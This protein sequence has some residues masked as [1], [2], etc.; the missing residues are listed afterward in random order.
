MNIFCIFDS[1]DLVS[2]MVL[3][4][5]VT[6]FGGT[7]IP[8]WFYPKVLEKLSIFLPFWYITFEAINYG[9]GKAPLSKAFQSLGMAM[10]W[11]V[12]LFLIGHLIWKRVQQRMAI[13]GG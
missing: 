6:F 7:L 4:A 2:F 13:N 12:L 10:F 3:R 1:G 9:L 11:A 5:G 8:L